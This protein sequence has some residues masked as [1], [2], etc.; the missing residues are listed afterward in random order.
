MAKITITRRQTFVISKRLYGY[1]SKYL[2]YCF[3][4]IFG[5]SMYALSDYL[6]ISYTKP[7]VDSGLITKE[8]SFIAMA[9]YYIMGIFLLRGLATFLSNYY[10]GFVG[11][12]VI[13]D[14]RDEMM[15]KL[16]FLPTSFYTKYTSSQIISKVNY[17]VEQVAKAMSEAIATAIKGLFTAIALIIL[18]FS[19]N[20]QITLIL[21]TVVPIIGGFLQYAAAKLRR[22]SVH[23][24]G[25]MASITKVTSEIIR[26]QTVIKNLNSY[27]IEKQK[28]TSVTENNKKRSL[29]AIAIDSISAPI[30]QFIGSLGLSLLCY[31]AT[32]DSKYLN[33]NLSA[34]E[35]VAIFGATLNLL[36]P[37]KQVA[38]IN[39]VLQQAIAGAHSIFGLMDFAQENTNVGTKLLPKKI[40]IEF[41][42]LSFKYENSLV[43]QNIN[44]NIKPGETVA[45]VG[46]SGSGKSTLLALIPRFHNFS[47]E[48][49][50]LQA[51]D[52][53]SYNLK[54][55]RNAI[56]YV[57]QDPFLFEDTIANNISY[58]TNASF[59]EIVAIT[60]KV[61]LY[62]FIQTLPAKFNTVVSENG[63][64]VS[65]GQKQKIAIARA[66]LLEREIL[67]LDEATS[68]LDNNSEQAIQE[69]LKTIRGSRTVLIATHKLNTAINADKIVVLDDGKVIEQGAF[70]TLIKNKSH[71]YK[72]YEALR[73]N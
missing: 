45:F 6:L 37:I 63:V 12:S 33:T 47:K 61:N 36:R 11:R 57:N 55:L 18:M 32:L 49:L 62:H 73:Y 8:P 42:N 44:L 3:I 40:N 43:L 7:L 64:K 31:L 70:K 51:R 66:L 65:S 38:S 56:A 21:L 19:I 20:W 15:Y 67:I 9:P 48:M 52:I 72:L 14:L 26:A 1:L 10:S 41:R 39:N 23:I 58:G 16:M 34:G 30:M 17:D 5:L 24:Q 13:K 22:Y 2:K 4:T 54:S 28:V 29:Q 50:L 68:N 60:K 35:F 27:N 53:N 71:F 46:K 59:S 25:S 69:F